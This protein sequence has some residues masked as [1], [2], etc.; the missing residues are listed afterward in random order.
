MSEKLSPPLPYSTQAAAIVR[1]GILG[2]RYELG[3]RLNEVE[4]AAS[5]GISRSP[6]R[7][8]LRTLVEEGLVTPVN[9][10]GFF[11]ASFSADEVRELLELRQA[12]DVLA[13]RLAAARAT[14]EDLDR[15]GQS[16]ENLTAAHHAQDAGNSPWSSDFHLGIFEAARN[17]KLR[18]HGWS[19]HTQL[20]LARFRSGAAADRV[21]EAHAEHRALLDAIRAHDADEAERRMRR[22]LA[23]GGEHILAV[24]EQ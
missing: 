18:E 3:Q 24:L 20:R 12:L 2:G 7:E 11:V 1:A 23:R 8:G 6:V 15:L 21:E 4:L 13:V 14:D 16:L 5:L 9:G 10:R 19:V 17:R 22:H